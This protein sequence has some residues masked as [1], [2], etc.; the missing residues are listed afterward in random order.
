MPRYNHGMS[1]PK[2]AAKPHY[3]RIRDFILDGIKQRTFAPGAK[4]PPEVELARQGLHGAVA[5]G[6][7]EVHRLLLGG[8]QGERVEERARIGLL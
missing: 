1:T 2:P 6:G 7:V 3:L 8:H 5:D 4:I